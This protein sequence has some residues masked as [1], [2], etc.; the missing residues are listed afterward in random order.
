VGNDTIGV[1]ATRLGYVSGVDG[2]GILATVTF[3]AEVKG[4]TTLDLFE[5]HLADSRPTPFPIEHTATAGFFT[6]VA[7]FPQAKFTYA[8]TLPKIN[9]TIVFDASTSSDPDGNIERYLWDFGD[10]EYANETDPLTNH[11]FSEGGKYNVALTVI[12]N[13]AFQNTITQEV[14]VM[15]VH[16]VA[17]TVVS[18]SHETVAAGDTVTI[19]VTVRN[20]GVETETFTVK[21]YYDG[22]EAAAA[23]TVSSLA[24]GANKTLMFYWEIADVE[25]GE[26]RIK[27]VAEFVPDEGYTGDNTKLGS[28]ITVTAVEELP[29]SLIVGGI[30]AL[31]AVVIISVYL[32]RRRGKSTS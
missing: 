27:A 32:L 6:N 21:A 14:K 1:G 4:E 9:E 5:T 28:T 23:Q 19:T 26:Y 30:G 13:D 16:D 8:P 2:S 15:F 10:D 12:D 17:V 11:A 25:P 29:W 18:L 24:S 22:T 31:A 20:V 3:I 7:G